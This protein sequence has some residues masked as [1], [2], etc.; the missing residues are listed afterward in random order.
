MANICENNFYACSD[1]STN[2]EVIDTFLGDNMEITD[3]VYESNYIEARFNSSWTFPEKQMQ[4][5]FNL[6]PDKND[7]FMRCLSA[8]FGNDY[9]AYWKCEGEK[10][11]YLM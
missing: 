4:A 9:I 2:L 3:Y 10:G 8:E 1:N 11:W 7:I 5:L 6:L